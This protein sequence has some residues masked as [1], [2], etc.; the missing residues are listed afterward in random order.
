MKEMTINNY[1]EMKETASKIMKDY[2]KKSNEAE[3]Y[4]KDRPEDL[5]LYMTG[6]NNNLEK[7]LD[8]LAFSYYFRGLI[9]KDIYDILNDVGYKWALHEFGEFIEEDGVD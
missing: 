6:L 3:Y 1:N 5:D 9:V 2:Q 8:D 4:Y 7:E